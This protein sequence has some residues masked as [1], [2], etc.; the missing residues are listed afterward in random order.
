M[1]F[2][3]HIGI[4][5]LVVTAVFALLILFVP[6]LHAEKK[7]VIFLA[8][9]LLGLANITLGYL[10]GFVATVILILPIVLTLGLFGI[11]VPV[12]VNAILIKV[13]DL[14]YEEFEV[15]GMGPLVGSAA[16]VSLAA[17]I[18]DRVFA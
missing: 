18:V 1:A 17:F 13:V 2:L 16:V 15:Q 8:A 11:V 12:I 14:K 3:A 7:K 9:P 10:L 6:K 4:K 5:F